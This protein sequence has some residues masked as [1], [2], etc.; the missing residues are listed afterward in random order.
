MDVEFLCIA[1]NRPVDDNGAH[2]EPKLHE[3]AQSS[4]HVQTLFDAFRKPGRFDTNAAA[5]SSLNMDVST[6]NYPKL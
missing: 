3:S 4:D 2:E 5:D 6:A 1:D